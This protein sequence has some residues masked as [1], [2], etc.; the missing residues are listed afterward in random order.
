[1]NSTSDKTRNAFHKVNSNVKGKIG[2][3]TNNPRLAAEGEAEQS[4]VKAD[5]KTGKIGP[6]HEDIARLAY[7]IWQQ[8]G[9]PIGTPEED[10]FRA[11]EEIKQH[12][13]KTSTT[14]A[15]KSNDT[16]PGK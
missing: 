12:W 5:K 8:R 3:V 14:P 4:V 13:N 15:V 10:W 7:Q 16:E 11:E 1:M 9:C 2:Q 6:Q